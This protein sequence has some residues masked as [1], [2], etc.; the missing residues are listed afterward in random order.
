MN[1]LHILTAS[2]ELPEGPVATY[3]CSSLHLETLLP[4]EG[5]HP[6]LRKSF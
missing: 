2:Y 4:V 3:S 5:M 6:R 1:M